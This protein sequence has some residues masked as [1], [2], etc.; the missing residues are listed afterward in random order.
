M[1]SLITSITQL[2]TELSADQTGAN[3]HWLD[4]N[5]SFSSIFGANS[6][7]F[8]A[9]TL[10]SFA[11]QITLGGCIDTTTCI[12]ITAQ[13]FY[14]MSGYIPMQGNVFAWPLSQI[15][16]CDASALAIISGGIQPW[17]YDWFTQ[18]HNEDIALIDSLC[19]GFHTVKVTDN[20]G[21]TLLIDYYITDSINY[22]PWYNNSQNNLDTLYLTSVNCSLDLNLP[23]DSASIVN[24]TY[25]YPD[26]NS[27]GDYYAIDIA[28]YQ[29]G[30][31]WIYTDTV[32]LIFG[33]NYLIY[34]NVFCPNKS[35]S[36]IKSFFIQFSFPEILG[37]FE[38]EYN[39]I[40][41]FPNPTSDIINI[42][43]NETENIDRIDIYDATGRLV[44]SRVISSGNNDVQISTQ[45]IS[46]GYYLL[47]INGS[48]DSV[49]QF[50][51]N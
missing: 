32:S 23:L 9:D 8:I 3:Y 16:S 36:R 51:K 39:K 19:Y 35:V 1:D 40:M 6:S 34:F 25:L 15:T 2:N 24:M 22:Y 14:N 26:T 11:C 13:N 43:W 30:N 29:S 20:I 49:I 4:C 5:N 17:H 10:G 45:E 37:I 12:D 21:D 7:N 50:I 18:P 48:F 28:Y 31:S 38:N 46:P 41:V 42:K 47:K 27:N 33:G 44:R